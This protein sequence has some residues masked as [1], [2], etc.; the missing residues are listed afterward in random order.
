METLKSFLEN[1]IVAIIC[2][3]VLV[4]YAIDIFRGAKKASDPALKWMGL[5]FGGLTIVV[6]TLV[7]IIDCVSLII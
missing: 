4:W 1:P 6:F 2:D 3:V 5:V 7:L